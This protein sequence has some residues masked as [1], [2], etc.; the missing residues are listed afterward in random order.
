MVAVVRQVA[1]LAVAVGRME[2]V[3]GNHGR[4]LLGE[5]VLDHLIE[6]FVLPRS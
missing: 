3:E 4:G 2:R 1:V 5:V 6:I